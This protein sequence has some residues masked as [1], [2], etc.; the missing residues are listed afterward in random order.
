[1][2][3]AEALWINLLLAAGLVLFMWEAP[4]RRGWPRLAMILVMNGITCVYV[5]WRVNWTLPDF[6][7]TPAALWPWLFFACEMV[8]ILYETWS[9]S[10]LLRVTDHSPE[11]DRHERRLRREENLP[12]VD[13]FI[14][15]FNEGVDILVDT[16][17]AALALDYPVGRVKVWIL[18]DG[19]RPWLRDLCRSRGVG[20]IARPTHEHG[21]AGNL[22]HAL[23]RTQGEFVLGIDADFCLNKDFIFRTLGF[24]LYRQGVGL[25][26]TPQ[27]F[28]NPDPVQHNLFGA[29]AWTEE[30]NFFMTVAQSARDAHEN[31]FCVGSG[32]LVPR[33]RLEEMGGF[34]Q[35]SLCE[36][37]EISYVLRGRGWRTLFLNETLAHG[38]AP[39][40]VPEY[41]KQRV[42][43][44]GGTLQHTFLATGPFRGRGLSF[45]DRLFY[46]EPI[47]YWLTYPFMVLVLIAPL[48]FWFTGVAVFQAGAEQMY[49]L[50]V[51]RLVAGYLIGYWLSEGKVLPVVTTVHKSLPAFHLTAALFK[52]A[53]APF[54]RPF[55]VTAKGQKRDKVVVQWQIAWIFLALAVALLG[56]MAPNLTGYYEIVQLGELTAIDVFWSLFT[57]LILALCFLACI[58]LP[59]TGVEFTGEVAKANGW[60]TIGGLWKRLIA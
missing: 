51:P 50:L 59:R 60:A 13:V 11:A 9:L 41:I 8:A 44:C 58:E 2:F 54:G 31:A 46:M 12:T 39:E 38:L 32:W 23:P 7:W 57:L 24:L 6:A 4:S 25:V 26:Q 34:P 28:R 14:P 49:L 22:N 10:V 40:S 17:R 27:H 29:A 30:Q 5:G 56:G 53:V 37:L 18:D 19:G 20:Y 42:R 1:M 3:V 45:L 35:G 21:K 15:T 52:F 36:D 48:V 16:L 55:Q 33:A 43:W 47:L